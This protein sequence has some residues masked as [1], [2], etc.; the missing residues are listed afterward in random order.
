MPLSLGGNLILPKASCKRC[1]DIT[2][3]FEQVC[4]RAIFG[5][6]RIRLNMP[7]RNRAE[8]PAE[9]PVP[10]RRVDGAWERVMVPANKF[11]AHFVGAR[12]PPPGIFLGNEPTDLFHATL[13]S[14]TWREN[15]EQLVNKP[16][17]AIQLHKLHWGA[18]CKLL[19]KIAHGFAVSQVGLDAFTHFLPDLILGKSNFFPHF[20][21]G[22]PVRLEKPPSNRLCELQLNKLENTEYLFVTIRLFCFLDAPQYA[23]VVGE[24][25]RGA[26]AS[27]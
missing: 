6:L 15:I 19:V 24:D 11:P 5:P 9:L 18:F 20:I 2:K 14:M 13:V 16:G 1:A 8:R 22:D 21:G 23:V 12:L 26:N 17:E 10:I 7:T 3:K 27:G 4:A 25:V